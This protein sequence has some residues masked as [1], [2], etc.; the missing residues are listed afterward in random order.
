MTISTEIGFNQHERS[1]KVFHASRPALD[2]FDPFQ[3]DLMRAEE[4]QFGIPLFELFCL[5]V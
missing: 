4:T 3:N 2:G 1:P 5:L